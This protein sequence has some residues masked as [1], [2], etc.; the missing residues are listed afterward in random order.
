MIHPATEL[1]PAGPGIGLG[2]FATARIPRGT[3]VW[4]LDPLDRLLTQAE[5]AALPKA[6]GFD[7]K[8]HLWLGP[9]GRYVL[10]WDLARYVNH[11]CTPN[12]AA[13]V[14]GCELA[15]A[16]IAA[17]D[18]LTNDYADLGMS[19][20]ETLACG[21]GALDCRGE[22]ASGQA[23]LIRQA[24]ATSMAQAMGCVGAVAQPLWPLLAESVRAHL[25]AADCGGP[26]RRAW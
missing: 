3:V 7:P 6:M 18:Q 22:V 2:V 12:C 25:L 21:C 1:R 10:A 11:S 13:T 4:V 9:D 24:L 26:V 17:G 23:P 16:D 20:G 19:P 8:R 15:L 14:F 5:V